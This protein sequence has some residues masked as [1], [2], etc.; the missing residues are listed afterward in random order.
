MLIRPIWPQKKN[1]QHFDLTMYGH[2]EVIHIAMPSIDV[3]RFL[4]LF[5]IRSLKPLK[6]FFFYTLYASHFF[7]EY[8]T[9]ARKVDVKF[10][11]SSFKDESP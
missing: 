1:L 6:T 5:L 10:L 8:Y 3:P 4:R 9:L 2:K 11:M 7:L